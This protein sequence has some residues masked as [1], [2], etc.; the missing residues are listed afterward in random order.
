MSL[1]DKLRTT[2]A[3]KN[4][5]GEITRSVIPTGFDTFDYYNGT[6]TA[7]GEL[8]VGVTGGKILYVCGSSGSGKSSFA[9]AAGFNIASS[10]EDGLLIVYDCEKSNT[11]QRIAQVTGIPLTAYNELHRD[12]KVLLI[13]DD[14][15]T[16]RLYGLITELHRVK[17]QECAGLKYTKDGGRDRKMDG[18][19]VR[20]S[21]QEIPPTVI[22]LDSIANL[23]PNKLEDD[24]EARTSMDA[25]QIAKANN[26]L[27][28]SIM[29]KLF[30]ANIMLFVI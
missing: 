11:H 24:T 7:D 4:L 27:I 18:R 6:I 13:N 29:N 5:G 26:G 20:K 3:E 23:S 17:M 12:K 1:L 16:E 8:Q 25:S 30:E 14:T 9:L 21:A 28:K 10:F 15:S 2:I 19:K 22:I